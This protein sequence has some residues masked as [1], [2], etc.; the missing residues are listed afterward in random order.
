MMKKLLSNIFIL[1]ILPSQALMGQC[2]IEQNVITTPIS[3]AATEE[4][5]QSFT[6]CSSAY[7]DSI[8]VNI[9]NLSMSSIQLK[10]SV[11]KGITT[12]NNLLHTQLIQVN[13]PGMLVIPI[14]KKVFVEEDVSYTFS[15]IG[16]NGHG[17]IDYAQ[18]LGDTYTGGQLIRNNTPLN[19]FDLFF[20]VYISQKPFIPTFSQWGLFI[21]GL[22]VLSLGIFLLRF[23]H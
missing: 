20:S 7:L 21:F 10:L 15:F 2:I 13:N 1:F 3:V 19:S 4:I 12:T 22:V 11:F 18:T 14:D 9:S 5:G 6:S 23:L 17:N 8:K 16:V